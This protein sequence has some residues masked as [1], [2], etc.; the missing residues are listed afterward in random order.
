MIQATAE[1]RGDLAR[2]CAPC[3]GRQRGASR[4][5]LSRWQAIAAPR[6]LLARNCAVRLDRPRPRSWRSI[7]PPGIGSDAKMPG[8]QW[9]ALSGAAVRDRAARPSSVRRWPRR[10]NSWNAFAQSAWGGI[11]EQFAFRSADGRRLECATSGRPVALLAERGSARLFGARFSRGPLTS[12]R[13]RRRERAGQLEFS[14]ARPSAVRKQRAPPSAG[15]W[16][17]WKRGPP[18][19]ELPPVSSGNLR[20][21]SRGNCSPAD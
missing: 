16:R 8:A 20:G 9:R 11:P 13:Q 3:L 2:T 15:G 6:E 7:L 19:R 14:A 21:K 17:S 1:T 18:L 12:L 10:A 5:A 4:R